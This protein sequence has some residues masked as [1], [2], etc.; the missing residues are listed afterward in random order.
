LQVYRI[1]G[2]RAGTRVAK[3]L[4][5]LGCQSAG[6]FTLWPDAG[7]SVERFAGICEQFARAGCA[8]NVSAFA[9]EQDDPLLYLFKISGLTNLGIRKVIAA[10]RPPAQADNLW[11]RWLRFERSAPSKELIAPEGERM[12]RKNLSPL[13]RELRQG[14]DREFLAQTCITILDTAGKQL[15]RLQ[16]EKLFAKALAE[17][18]MHAWICA[19]D[20]IAFPALAFLREQSIRVPEDISLISFDN[21][22]ATALEQRLTTFDFNGM[23]FV[24]A[25]L[26]FVVRP[27]RLR[28]SCRHAAIEIAGMII[29]RGTTAAASGNKGRHH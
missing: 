24:R 27:Q 19:A 13:A 6:Y 20:S 18:R 25:I 14:W 17:P 28:G 3:H 1:E 9:V 15:V 23:G 26:N 11:E 29:E 2:Q 22:P 5:A 12:L 4:L 21:T 16:L 7:W 10:I 8:G